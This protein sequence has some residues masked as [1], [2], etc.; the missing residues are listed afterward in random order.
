LLRFKYQLVLI[1]AAIAVYRNSFEGVLLLDDLPW[2]LHNSVIRNIWPLSSFLADSARPLVA[3]SLAL[4]FAISK[5]HLWSYHATNL[6]IHISASLAFFGLIRITLLTPALHKRFAHAASGLAFSISLIWIVHPLN[7]QA[8][9]YIVQRGESMMGL[10]YIMT[11]YSLIQYTNASKSKLWF[12][13]AITFCSLGMATK[14]TMISAPFIALFYDRTFLA[15]SIK[16][17]WKQ[18]WKL[19]TGLFLS[20]AI[21]A[22]LLFFHPTLSA[23]PLMPHSSP[24]HYAIIQPLI[25]IKYLKLAF[26]PN[27]LLFDYYNYDFGIASF[28]DLLGPA[29]IVALMISAT[30]WAIRRGHALG[31]LGLW[32]FG[33][34]APSSSFIP[35]DDLMVEH[36]MYLPLLAVI[37]LVVFVL[38]NLTIR[39]VRDKTLKIGLPVAL[40]FVVVWLL[41]CKTY[42]RNNVYLSSLSMWE[43]TVRKNP[44]NSRALNYLG[45]SL[46]DAGKLDRAV[47]SYEKSL[48]IFDDAGVY[49]NL[50]NAHY[51]KGELGKAQQSYSRALS[52]KPRYL[53]VHVKAHYQMANVFEDQGNLAEAIEHHQ[54]A[55]NLNPSFIA[56]KQRII[57]IQGQSGRIR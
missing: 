37:A 52:R 21:L 10:C 50:G 40:L 20:I 29:V 16:M 35:I 19:H 55:L 6:L 11:L 54:M 31:F 1:I 23:G 9:T 3:F 24:A 5:L 36:R 45:I 46:I 4:N 18:R 26:Y 56:S 32:F 7:T 15:G 42:A 30:W 22:A 51:L 33:I 14:P 28:F 41:G 27:S 34:L 38:W 13:A 43:D 57:D 53:S 12:I 17:A 48:K 44:T 2:I 8:V 39:Y 25:I 47:S 49:L